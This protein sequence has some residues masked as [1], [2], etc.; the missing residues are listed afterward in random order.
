MASEHF[1]P[2]SGM[3]DI[4]FPEVAQWHFMEHVA[5]ELLSRYGLRE[6]R[7]PI[8][9]RTEVFVR[10]LGDGTDVVQ[11]EMYT[12]EDR[13]GRSLTLRP[14]GTAGIARYL[15][16]QGT[17][18]Q[19]ARI[20]YLGPMFRCERPQAGR[21]RQFHQCGVE[22]AGDPCPAAD[23]ECVALQMDL[24]KAWGLEGCRLFLNTRGDEEDQRRLRE[25]LTEQLRAHAAVLCEECRRR[26]DTNVLRV[27][28]CKQARCRAVV[29]G[30]P[31]QAECM[32]AATRAYFDT[33]VDLL[34]HMGYTPEINPRLVRGLDY[35]AHT[36]WEITHPALGAQ[37]AVAGGGRYKVDL[38]GRTVTGV[39]F[40]MGLERVLMVRA[41]VVP[42]EPDAPLV[43]VWLV[44]MGE[45][46]LKANLLLQQTL[47]AR[48]VSC[49]MDLRG[50]GAKAQMRA[51]NRAG[52]PFVVVRGD[53]ELAAGR[54]TVKD[55]QTGE[56]AD[57]ALEAL[58]D[59][60]A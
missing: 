57:M 9:E 52:A 2:I 55:M 26:L 16:A 10:S 36:V 18:A 19:D 47:R 44:S 20:Y 28:D 42:P 12:L 13:G 25:G 1:Q 60:F 4:D 39:G 21:K 5:R 53:N 15:A 33:V 43:R 41:A 30:L 32:S 17:G 46:A 54:Y 35:Y 34:R 14:E 3:S 40:A 49:A 51:A 45:A 37:D 27:L 23:A 38:F 7:T 48:G 22:M 31:P 56:Q 24:L 29:E 11:K 50:R 8:L 59:K 58:L 6:V